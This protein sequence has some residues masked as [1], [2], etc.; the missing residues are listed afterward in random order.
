M[1]SEQLTDLI[2][3]TLVPPQSLKLTK[4]RT[5]CNVIAFK[6]AR[7]NGY[8]SLPVL[9]NLMAFFENTKGSDHYFPCFDDHILEA[10]EIGIEFRR[11]ADT[12]TVREI[13]NNMKIGIF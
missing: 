10:G 2:V 6:L 9:R 8:I 4:V 11:D 3:E 1:I 7:A 13:L 12:N 5:H